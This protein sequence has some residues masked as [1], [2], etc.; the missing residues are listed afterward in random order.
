MHR[1]TPG[2]QIHPDAGCGRDGSG[3]AKI[4]GVSDVMEVRYKE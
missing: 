4:H 2:G 1:R 3:L